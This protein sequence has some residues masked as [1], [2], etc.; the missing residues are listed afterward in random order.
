MRVHALSKKRVRWIS[1]CG[2]GRTRGCFALQVISCE[3]VEAVGHEN[4]P[5]YFAAIA[6]ALRPGGLAVI[7]VGAASARSDLLRRRQTQRPSSSHAV[8]RRFLY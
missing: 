3:M 6:R 8:K 1:T 2:Q 7:Q 5:G 4:L